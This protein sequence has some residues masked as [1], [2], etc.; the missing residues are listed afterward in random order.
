MIGLTS[1]QDVLELLEKRVKSRF[2]H[3]KLNV[4]LPTAPRV[5]PAPADA[6]GNAEAPPE[7]GLLD[8]L[9]VRA[10]RSCG[11]D[12]VLAKRLGKV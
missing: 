5:R 7:D 2:S 3:R 4:V 12:G 9:Q 8:V 11:C 6:A 10:S 1:R